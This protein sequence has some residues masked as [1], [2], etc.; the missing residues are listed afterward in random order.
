MG[1]HGFSTRQRRVQH[2]KSEHC[3]TIDRKGCAGERG[4]GKAVSGRTCLHD[5]AALFALLAAFPRLAAAGRWPTLA[6]VSRTPAHGPR[7]NNGDAH[8]D[9]TTGKQQ[10]PHRREGAKD[11]KRRTKGTKKMCCGRSN[12]HRSALTIAMRVSCSPSL[13][14][15]FFPGG[16]LFGNR[17]RKR[18]QT[19]RLGKWLDWMRRRG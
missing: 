1:C 12:P 14:S 11:P 9:L 13:L 5:G 6:A 3:R 17:R 4:V 15:L 10:L 8:L 18:P 2:A 19:R 16:I 7:T